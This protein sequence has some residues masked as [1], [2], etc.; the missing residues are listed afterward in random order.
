MATT[1]SPTIIETGYLSGNLWD[2][3][4]EPAYRDGLEA[5]LA[6]TFPGAEIVI[7]VEHNASGSLP[8]ACQTRVYTEDGVTDDDDLAMEVG[9]VIDEFNRRVC[10]AQGEYADYWIEEN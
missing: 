5:F 10:E 3:I 9:A 4:D 7:T 8:W 2:G 1:V 6:E